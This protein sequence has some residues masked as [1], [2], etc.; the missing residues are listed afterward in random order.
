MPRLYNRA[1]EPWGHFMTL[2][3]QLKVLISIDLGVEETWRVPASDG[4][5]APGLYKDTRKLS[6]GQTGR[7]LKQRTPNIKRPCLVL[8]VAICLYAF[9]FDSSLVIWE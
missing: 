8:S 5:L 2:E 3:A 7:P 9:C 6:L 1:E 4:F